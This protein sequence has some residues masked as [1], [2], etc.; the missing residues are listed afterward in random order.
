MLEM[1][2]NAVQAP[3]EE[4]KVEEEGTDGLLLGEVVE[5]LRNGLVGRIAFDDAAR[6]V[7][8]GVDSGPCG[9]YGL[10]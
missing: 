6:S 3:R 7:A 2:L 5:H 4:D 1:A 8:C 10:V 9:R